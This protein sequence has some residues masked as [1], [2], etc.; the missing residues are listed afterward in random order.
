MEWWNRE[1]KNGVV[2]QRKE[3]LGSG[4][5]KRRAKQWKREEMG[6]VVE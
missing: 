6:G 4:T 3:E 1:G 2:E 5:E